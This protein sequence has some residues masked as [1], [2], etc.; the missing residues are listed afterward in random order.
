MQSLCEHIHQILFLMFLLE[1]IFFK[2]CFSYEI[3]A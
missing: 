2:I 3:L 1:T